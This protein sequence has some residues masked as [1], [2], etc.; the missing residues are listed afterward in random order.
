[1]PPWWRSKTQAIGRDDA[2]QLVQRCEVHRTLGGG[3]QPLHVAADHMGLVFR[4]RAIRAR[5]HTVTEVPVPVLYLGDQWIAGR[6]RGTSR[7]CNGACGEACFQE[8]TPG[9]TRRLGVGFVSH[10]RVLRISEE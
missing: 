4:R 7:A 2:V 6:A 8:G 3:R 9:K 10:D 1:M 5:L